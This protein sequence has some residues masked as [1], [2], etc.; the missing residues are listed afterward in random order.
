M[1]FPNEFAGIGVLA[2]GG[3]AG[4]LFVKL[5]SYNFLFNIDDGA[6]GGGEGDGLIGRS[7]GR[8][9]C[10]S[11]GRSVTLCFFRR[12]RA[13]WGLL[14]LPNCLPIGQFHHCPCPPVCDFGSRVFGLVT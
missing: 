3:S 13:I 4:V 7:V 14:L 5:L 9:V 11:V 8:S 12:L 2:M 6:P 10:R 1:D